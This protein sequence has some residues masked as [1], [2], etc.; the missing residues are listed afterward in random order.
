MVGEKYISIKE[1]IDG[2]YADSGMDY[3]LPFADLLT[4]VGDAINLIGHP[5]QYINKIIGHQDYTPFD[6][7]HYRAQLPC[8]FYKLRQLAVDGFPVYPSS[9]SFHHLMDGECCGIDQ[10]GGTDGD[11]FIDNFGNVF[12]TALG[13]K[14]SSE[15]VTY[16]L[17]N[18]WLT[19]S[20]ETGKVCMSYWAFPTDDDGYPMVPDEI[21]YKEYVKKYLTYKLD[22]IGWRK[23]TIQ[24]KVFAKS[25]QE[26]LFYVGQ[27]ANKAKTLDTNAMESLKSQM[28]RLLPDINAFSSFYKQQN[29]PEQR[30]I[31]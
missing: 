1:I 9:H 12:N 18:N 10:L 27:A 19:L 3:D 16:T 2:V 20:V 7:T 5:N 30:K 28:I 11:S 6:I 21:S 13:T 23:G 31:K 15:P 17:S 25:E 14:Y 4:W 8:D 24:D 22:Y 29:L 26:Y